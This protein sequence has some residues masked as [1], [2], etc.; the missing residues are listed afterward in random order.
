M[1]S[2]QFR[3][4]ALAAA[5]RGWHVFP[6]HP[7][8][9]RPAIKQ[10]EQQAT[11]D[12]QQIHQWWPDYSRKNIGVAA[13]PSGLL[14]VDLDQPKNPTDLAPE[15]WRSRGAS[16]GADVLELAAADRAAHL[17]D[18]FTVTTPSGGRHLYFRQP[19]TG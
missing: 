5:R 12:E 19:A 7:E 13:G 15:P 11:I 9:K 10:W 1:S 17:P 4:A 18:T 14:V 8:S 3:Q 2:N 6:C 16:T